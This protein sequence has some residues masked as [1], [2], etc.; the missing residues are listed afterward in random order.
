MVLEQKH[1]KNVQTFN[2]NMSIALLSGQIQVHK[3]QVIEFGGVNIGNGFLRFYPY[4]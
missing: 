1:Y 4:K 3:G 2:G